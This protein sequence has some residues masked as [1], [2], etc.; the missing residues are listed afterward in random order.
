MGL[1]ILKKRKGNPMKRSISLFL[2]LVMLI[3]MF[4]ISAFAKEEC[5][6]NWEFI[7]TKSTDDYFSKY[8]YPSYDEYKYHNVYCDVKIY[9]CSKCNEY[10]Y[11]PGTEHDYEVQGFRSEIF[12]ET[13]E[14]KCKLCGAWASDDDGEGEYEG[15]STARAHNFQLSADV[16]KLVCQ[17]EQCGMSF[18]VQE[19]TDGLSCRIGLN[20]ETYVPEDIIKFTYHEGEII[21]IDV[22]NKDSLKDLVM[23][24]V[25]DIN[26]FL[27]DVL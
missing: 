12:N 21:S 19:L 27:R 22:P 13:I 5:N 9:K 26:N 1:F 7:E 3:T 4:P 17:N 10:K 11:E 2:A 14:Y 16:K 24:V 15:T 6:H 23:L 20:E 8:D 25:G 18:N